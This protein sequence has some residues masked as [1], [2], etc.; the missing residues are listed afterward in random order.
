MERFGGN[1]PSGKTSLAY[2]KTV[3]EAQVD[4]IDTDK[5]SKLAE[6]FREPLLL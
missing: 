2:W 5:V 6:F 1:D 4:L 3:K